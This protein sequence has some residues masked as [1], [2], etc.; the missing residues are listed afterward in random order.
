[1]QF[2]DVKNNLVYVDWHWVVGVGVAVLASFLSSCGLLLQK[3]SH[4]EYIQ[5]VK[6]GKE[7]KTDFSD[8]SE[9]ESS[10]TESLLSGNEDGPSAK[11][12]EEV[13]ES[14]WGRPKWVAGLIM[15]I[16]ASLG[17]FV[18]L[19]LAAQSLVASLGSLNVVFNF[20]MTPKFIG[21]KVSKTDIRGTIAVVSGCAGSIVFGAHA[22]KVFTLDMIMDRYQSLAYIIYI[23]VIVV[24][25]LVIKASIRY[26]ERKM[27]DDTA[28]G[29]VYTYSKRMFRFHQFS[30]PCIS[31][32]VGAQTVLFAKS[33]GEYVESAIM[34]AANM[35]TS[36]FRVLFI[37]VL[38]LLTVSL[39]MK[40]LNQG[41][42]RFD[43]LFV[44]PV[45]QSFWIM[46]SVIGGMIFFK[47]YQAFSL[48]HYF[49]FTTSVFVVIGGVLYLSTK[50]S[51]QSRNHVEIIR[52]ADNEVVN[53]FEDQV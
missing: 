23:S 30:Y 29:Y 8:P 9:D 4:E 45:F 28:E 32:L 1:M 10:M 46:G 25:I 33:I 38:M 39:Q 27:K 18:A 50:R 16:L 48:I 7:L 19:T 35:R 22:T 49:G 15:I 44:V 12:N 41:L 3:I 26:I 14:L 21:E 17:D 47:E 11:N 40:W 6:K 51:T 31:G 36:D 52:D 2:Q 34:D 24:T 20:L 5:S 43:A 42:A 53:V 13:S 37:L